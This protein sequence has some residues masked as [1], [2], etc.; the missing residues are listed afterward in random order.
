MRAIRVTQPGGPDVLRLAELPMP[1]PGRGQVRVTLRASGVNYIDVYE[2]TGLYPQPLPFTPGV[3]GAGVVDALGEDV[4]DLRVGDRVAWAMHGGSYA[5]HAVVDAWKVVPLPAGIEFTTAAA[6]LLQGMTAHY[7]ACSTFAVGPGH[8]ALVHAAA[9]GA[10]RLLVQVCKLRGAKVIGTV[11]SA[12]KA[13]LA[14][15]AGC[16]RVIRYDQESFTGVA[17]DVVYDSVGKATFMDSL[18]ALRPRGMLVLYGQSSGKV[19]PFDLSELATR[20]SLFVTR[21]ALKHYAHTREAIGLRMRDL[22]A[23]LARG[24]ISL[25]IDRTLPLAEAAQAHALLE[26]RATAGKLLLL[27]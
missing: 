15:A 22:F 16:D 21:P 17:A 7:L 11:S 23:W 8:T 20:G 25:R 12:A 10:G 6:L 18:A 5:E 19:P 4:A 26:S 2:R 27:P 24:A 14:R 1:M 3:E 9:G 13:E